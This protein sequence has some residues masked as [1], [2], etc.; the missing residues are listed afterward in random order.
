MALF[1]EADVRAAGRS[2]TSYRRAR[3]ILL[4]ES[5]EYSA[6]KTYDVFVSHSFSDAELILGVKKLIE[7]LGHSVYL[8]YVEDAEMDRNLVT[9]ATAERLRVRMNSSR[10]LF[11]AVTENSTT[12]KWMP[13]ELGYFDGAKHRAAVLPIVASRGRG[14]TYGGQEYLG[15]YPYAV[16]GDQLW[17]HRSEKV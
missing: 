13:W 5:K 10:S 2:A 3:D 6:R 16:N 7:G 15:L 1:N 9:A 12:S 8:D 14:D 4:A 11:F 17:I